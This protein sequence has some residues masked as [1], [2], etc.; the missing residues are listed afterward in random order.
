[1]YN[2]REKVLQISKL[3]L[4]LNQRFCKS[5]QIKKSSKTRKEKGKEREKEEKA[6]GATSS[7]TAEAAVAHFPFLPK[8]YPLSLSPATNISVSLVI[9]PGEIGTN[10][11]RLSEILLRFFSNLVEP[12]ALRHA[13][14]PPI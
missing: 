3:G 10:T 6:S 1:M 8:W 11:A 9:S 12:Y 13:T 4:I 2:N 5:F 14:P 7:A